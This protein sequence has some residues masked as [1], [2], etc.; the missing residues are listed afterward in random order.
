MRPDDINPRTGLT[1]ALLASF[2]SLDYVH[3]F[4]DK[5]E[6]LGDIPLIAIG[7]AICL[8][9]VATIILAKKTDGF[10]KW[11]D[12]KCVCCKKAKDREGMELLEASWGFESRKGSRDELDKH[13]CHEDEELKH[14]KDSASSTINL[15]ESRSV[16]RRVE[17]N[18]ILRYIEE[19]YSPNTLAA[20]NDDGTFWA[21]GRVCSPR[22]GIVYSTVG[23]SIGHSPIDSIVVYC[24]GSSSQNDRYFCYINPGKVDWEHE[25]IV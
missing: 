4:R 18:E 20:M 19:C 23:P 17:E 12:G 3:C 9:G 6:T 22:D 21:V 5:G 24:H 7:P 10:T 2:F 1:V 14:G 25:T 15:L 13:G 11:P 8:P 16:I